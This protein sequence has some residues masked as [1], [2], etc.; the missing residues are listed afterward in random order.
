MKTLP[1]IHA[2]IAAAIP[3]A[4]L[5]GLRQ[6]VRETPALRKMGTRFGPT[7]VFN[8]AEERQ[9]VAAYQAREN[10]KLATC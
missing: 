3:G 2:T 4:S 6:V 9:I 5:D 8:P 7:R 10:R 1:M